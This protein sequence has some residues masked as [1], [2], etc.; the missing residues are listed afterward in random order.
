M[1]HTT[2]YSRGMSNWRLSSEGS[3]NPTQQLWMPSS[4]ASS[5]MWSATIAESTTP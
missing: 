5:D 3:I 4:A 1:T 2:R